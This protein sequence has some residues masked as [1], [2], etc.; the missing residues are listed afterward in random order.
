MKTFNL[1]SPI[2]IKSV[3]DKVDECVPIRK[4][5]N[6][7]LFKQRNEIYRKIVRFCSTNKEQRGTLRNEIND[8]VIKP[9]YY[10]GGWPFPN[11]RGVIEALA[12]DIGKVV[13][14]LKLFGFEDEL[15]TEL[16]RVGIESINLIHSKFDSEFKINNPTAELNKEQIKKEII[17]L[18]SLQQEICETADLIKVSAYKQLPNH[19]KKSKMNPS[20]IDD[21]TFSE[22]VKKQLVEDKK[23]TLENF[24]EKAIIGKNFIDTK[25]VYYNNIVK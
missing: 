4:Y 6:N 7:V 17:N 3:K 18:L 1:K 23:K 2:D 11:S 24:T 15:N 21:E 13:Y 20:G 14:Y 8:F 16:N 19:I 22:L 12:E 10:K 9:L 25:E 5:I